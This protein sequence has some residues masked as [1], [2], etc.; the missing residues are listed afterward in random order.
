MAK[1][2]QKGELSVEKLAELFDNLS[3]PEN[4]LQGDL[5]DAA[6]SEAD[7][8]YDDVKN[9]NVEEQIQFL[10]LHGFGLARLEEI[11]REYADTGGNPL[12]D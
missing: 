9:E 11:I 12:G 1:K 2:R 5:R 7:L 6:D 10:Y 8:I 4:A 3:V